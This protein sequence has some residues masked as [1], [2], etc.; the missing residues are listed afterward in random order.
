[1]I[2]RDYFHFLL[3]HSCSWIWMETASGNENIPD[4]SVYIYIYAHIHMVT[5]LK[6]YLMHERINCIVY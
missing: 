3:L 2:S 6:L 5:Y 1:M 4:L